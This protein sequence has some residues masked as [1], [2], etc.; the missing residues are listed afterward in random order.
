MRRLEMRNLN[1]CS[2]SNVKIIF[3]VK[4][5]ENLEKSPNGETALR[6]KERKKERKKDGL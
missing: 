5:K 6:K 4:P 1:L 2:K 3:L